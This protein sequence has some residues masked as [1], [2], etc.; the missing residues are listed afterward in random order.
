MCVEMANV[1]HLTKPAGEI[2][3]NSRVDGAGELP[4]HEDP[5]GGVGEPA[6]WAARAMWSDWA[7]GAVT[8]RTTFPNMPNEIF[9]A[10]TENA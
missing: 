2:T 5:R 8:G 3:I 9:G 10:D 4:D 6:G 7:S 1:S